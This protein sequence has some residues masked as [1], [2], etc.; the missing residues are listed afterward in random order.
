MIKS[1]YRKN[2]IEQYIRIGS[3]VQTEAD[4]ES[5]NQDP[6]QNNNIDNHKI[7]TN[8]ESKSKNTIEKSEYVSK[9]VFWERGVTFYPLYKN[10]VL[11]ISIK[12]KWTQKGQGRGLYQLSVSTPRGG[13]N[14]FTA[15]LMNKMWN[16][17]TKLQ[18]T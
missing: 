7:K 10:C 18:Y 2:Q 6:K 11:A 13:V 17:K 4:S 14:R 3:P 1:D 16:L 12:G 9:Y 5:T 15:N 8:T